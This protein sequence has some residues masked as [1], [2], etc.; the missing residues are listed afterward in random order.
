MEYLRSNSNFCSLVPTNKISEK[1]TIS[2]KW[3][4]LSKQGKSPNTHS[5]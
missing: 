4:I 1:H 2:I 3:Y 5:Q